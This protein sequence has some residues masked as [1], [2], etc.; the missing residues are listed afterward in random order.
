M[1][2]RSPLFFL[3]TI[4]AHL[5]HLPVRQMAR[6]GPLLDVTEARHALLNRHDQCLCGFTVGLRT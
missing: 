3:R 1:I 4:Q 6:H 2:A 5:L